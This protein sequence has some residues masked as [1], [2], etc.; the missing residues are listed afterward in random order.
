LFQKTCSKRLV[1]KARDNAAAAQR[2]NRGV[3]MLNLNASAR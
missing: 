3:R 1:P 2:H